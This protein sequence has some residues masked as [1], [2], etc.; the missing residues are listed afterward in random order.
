[1]LFQG[2]DYGER[3]PFRF[4]SDHIDDEIAA[5]T[6]EGRRRE[7][8]AFADFGE[9][10]PDPQ[11]ARTLRALQAHPRGRAAPA[12]ATLYAA[13]LALRAELARGARRTR[14]V[15]GRRLT[16]RRG[17][18]R[19]LANFGGRPLAARR[20][21]GAHRRRRA[22]RRARAARRGGG[23]MREIW[24]GEPFPLGAAWDGGGTNFS[25]FSEN[26]TRVELCLF[27]DGR[28]TRSASS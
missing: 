11:D 6:R 2:E 5:A 7:F 17:P 10:V 3:A 8:A 15:D 21:A 22:R 12:C 28:G 4:F 1:M 19:I 26:A 25:L 9:E 13:A 20:R 16:V 14:S 24:P 23:P 27:D 18:Y